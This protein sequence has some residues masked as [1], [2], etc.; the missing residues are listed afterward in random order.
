MFSKSAQLS[1]NLRGVKKAEDRRVVTG[2]KVADD[3]G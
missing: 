3:E 2:K 1:F